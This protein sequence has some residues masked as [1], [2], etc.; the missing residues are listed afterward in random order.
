MKAEERREGMVR[1]L[2]S[3]AVAAALLLGSVTGAVLGTETT[4][5]MP[6]GAVS[7]A[8]AAQ[9][10]AAETAVL[11]GTENAAAEAAVQWEEVRRWT[12]DG[13]CTIWRTANGAR[14]ITGSAT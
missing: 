14:T 4:Q 9:G 8:D 2:L 12:T 13:R 5:G 11:P 10:T 6:T 7:G 1:R 3:T